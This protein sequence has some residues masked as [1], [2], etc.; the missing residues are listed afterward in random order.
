MRRILLS[1]DRSRSGK[2]LIT[3]AI[4]R[5]LSKKYRV[6]GFK[7]GP[8]FIDPGYHKIA[9]SFP[10]INLDLWMMGK[11]NVKRSLIKYGREFDI[12]II[13]GVMGLY[14]G[15]DT[16][17]ST[18]E[19]AKVTK[20]PV[21]LIINCSNIGSTVGAIVKGLKYYRNDVNIR[22]VIFNKIASETHYNYCRNAVEDVEVLGY[23]PFDKNLE[24]KSRHLG[25]VT[26]EDNKEVQDLIRYA[27]ELVEKYVDLDKIYEMASDEDLEVDLPKDDENKGLK[28]KMA[29]AYDPAFSFYYQE[30][31]DILRSR[32]ELEFFSP[33]NDEYV[34]DA[35][36]I[37]IGGGYPELHLNELERSSKTKSW[38]KNSS[39][40]GV[41][42]Y[43]EC[44]GLMYLS[45]NLIDENNKNYNMV[46]I[47]DIDIKTKDKLTIGYTELEAINE[48]F[49][50]NKNSLVRGHEFHISKPISVNEKEFVFKV[51]I[52]KGIVDKLDGVKSN[53]TIANYSHLHFSNFQQKIVF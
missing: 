37:Y 8:D 21:I 41:K 24:V 10:S 31:L 45:K 48:N 38:L 20:T 19:L 36:A 43:A 33:L 28:R 34:E 7:A 23:V 15:V 25:L 26:I 30:N 2:T 32:Y 18:Y 49:I 13:E 9:T 4:M 1:S 22:G 52:G 39:Y 50:A 51:R 16:L 44:G 27:S 17:Y 47:F 14:D 29:I 12:G 6:R 42:I 53:N 46:G 35:E 5:A 40:S 11:N 3:S